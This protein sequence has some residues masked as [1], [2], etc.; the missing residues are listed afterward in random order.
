MASGQITMR[1]VDGWQTLG[2]KLADPMP[3]TSPPDQSHHHHA[4]DDPA[5]PFPLHS[6]RHPPRADTPQILTVS[7]MG[8]V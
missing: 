4:G 8:S 7:N 2:E 3:V 6:R 5:R 1:K